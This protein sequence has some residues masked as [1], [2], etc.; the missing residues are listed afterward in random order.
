M[1][2]YQQTLRPF[3]VSELQ[4]STNSFVK[5]LLLVS[6]ITSML[7]LSFNCWRSGAICLFVRLFPSTWS[8]FSWDN[9]LFCTAAAILS[10]SSV[11]R[12]VFQMYNSSS[13]EA[14]DIQAENVPPRQLSG[15]LASRKFLKFVRD[16]TKCCPCSAGMWHSLTQSFSRGWSFHFKN[17]SARTAPLP[18]LGILWQI[19]MF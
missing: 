12:L 6:N 13:G 5:L 17:E 15:K 14:S 4:C 19:Q 10:R 3:L 9:L 7:W 8:L 11:W 1:S 16:F 2:K 18:Q